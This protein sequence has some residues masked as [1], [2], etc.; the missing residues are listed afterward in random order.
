MFSNKRKTIGVLLE[1]VVSEFQ[2]SL[3]Q[4]IIQKAEQLGYNVA[5]FGAYGNY[6]HNERYLVGDQ[7]LWELRS[8]RIWMELFWRWT[9]LKIWRGERELLSM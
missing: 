2:N 6:G 1:R 4:G 3:C 9:R 8:M 7:N 5:I